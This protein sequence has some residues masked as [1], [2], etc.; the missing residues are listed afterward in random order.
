MSSVHRIAS[1]A[2]VSF[3]ALLGGGGALARG[4]PDKAV[5]SQKFV[6]CVTD[7]LQESYRQAFQRASEGPVRAGDEAAMV[8][9]VI[10]AH[11]ST[12][13]SM[14]CISKISGVPEKDMPSVN[15]ERTWAAFY[16]SHFE[17]NAFD[18]VLQAVGKVMPAI[19]AEGIAILKRKSDLHPR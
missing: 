1:I 13:I 11:E 12:G 2:A 16:L 5:N 3:A 17:A 10:V 9:R 6:K 19:E 18:K 7:D 15:D 4:Q 8:N 14:A